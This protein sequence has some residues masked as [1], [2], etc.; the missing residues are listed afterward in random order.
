MPKKTWG[1]VTI[2][3]V[4]YSV[5]VYIVKGTLLSDN[6]K[7]LFIA[8]HTAL[9]LSVI[10]AEL[11]LFRQHF[12]T[13]GEWIRSLSNVGRAGKKHE[14]YRSMGNA[15]GY[16]VD[17]AYVTYFNN[18]GPSESNNPA[19]EQYHE[20]FHRAVSENGN[21][22]FRRIIALLPTDTAPKKDWVKREIDFAAVHENY[23]LRFLA[24]NLEP[25]LPLNVQIFDKFVFL[26]DPSRDNEDT[27]PR[28][29]HFLSEDIAGIWF[30]YYRLIWD[31]RSD[32]NP[33]DS[34]L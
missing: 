7:L 34:Y 20:Q 17:H 23:T 8:G 6:T 29:I 13:A 24:P 2:F 21:R 15:L 4:G 27:L 32:A 16:L 3:L 28:D 22:T 18:K 26:I 5:I 1:L 10:F 9:Y 12:G 19:E 14:L 11:S 33:P 25:D 31:A 30:R